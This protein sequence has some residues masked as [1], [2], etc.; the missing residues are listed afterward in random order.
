MTTNYKNNFKSGREI[1]LATV[2]ENGHPHANIVISLGFVD[3]KL[4]VAD[5]QMRT[6]IKN[7]QA[8]KQI[9]VIGGYIRIK[10]TVQIFTAGKYFDLAVKQSKGYQVKHAVL[11]T[12]KKIFDLDNSKKYFKF[13]NDYKVEEINRGAFRRRLQKVGQKDFCFAR[14]PNG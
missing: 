11:I 5:C 13:I 6:T 9:C 12:S 10:G 3:N 8:N 1:I 4:L 14:Q 2:G 7:L